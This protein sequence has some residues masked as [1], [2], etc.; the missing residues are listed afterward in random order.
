MGN[1]MKKNADGA[2]KN[3]IIKRKEIRFG[4]D[5]TMFLHKLLT[6]KSERT[7]YRELTIG[8]HH[9]LPAWANWQVI[10]ILQ[11]ICIIGVVWHGNEPITSFKKYRA[12]FMSEYGFQSFPAFE[13]V[14]KYTSSEDWD[15]SSDVMLNHQRSNIGNSRISEYMKQSYNIPNSFEDFLYV[16]QL[17]QAE[18]IKMAIE[19]HR[20]EMPYCMGS[21]YWQLNDCWPVASWSGIDY[22]GQWKALHYFV[23]EAFKTQI[24]TVNIEN[25]KINIYGISDTEGSS[26]SLRLNLMDY[27]GKSVWNRSISVTLPDNSSKL[28]TSV[29]FEQLP[30]MKHTKDGLLYVSLVKNERIIDSDVCYFDQ[31]KNLKLPFPEIK[32]HIRERPDDQFDIEIFSKNLCKNFMLISEGNAY[33]FPEN[34]FDILPGETK[35]VTIKTDMNYQEVEKK[36]SFT[37]LQEACSAGR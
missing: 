23:K 6:G 25:N 36:L 33:E 22:Y 1:N 9:L 11:A 29:D 26:A 30:V 15:I 27:Y 3:A 35:V 4:K 12:R 13:S 32:V 18:A 31:P 21:L 19:A 14:K 2:G 17:L 20:T 10:L 5:I 28:L 8:I 24:V 7:F 34:Y 37:H 16:S